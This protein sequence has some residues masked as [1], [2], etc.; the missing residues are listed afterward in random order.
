MESFISL[1]VAWLPLIVIVAILLLT[2]RRLSRQYQENIELSR[3]AIDAIRE[4]TDALRALTGRLG[5]R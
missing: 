1:L 5:E 2:G 3:T 4:N